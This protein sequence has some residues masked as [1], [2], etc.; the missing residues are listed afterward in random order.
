MQPRGVH[1]LRNLGRVEVRSVE[2]EGFASEIQEI[3]EQV[4]QQL[5][6]N[7]QKYKS[8]SNLKRREV[9][10]EVKEKKG[11]QEKSIIN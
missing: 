6:N 2:G 4:K 10:F 3:H 8:K 5:Q 9:N 7:S 1:E 11:F